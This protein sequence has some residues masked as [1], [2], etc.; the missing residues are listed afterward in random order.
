M[1]AQIQDRFELRGKP[2]ALA[3]V[4]GGDLFV[5]QHVGI[6]PQMLSTACWRGFDCLY[7]VTEVALELRELNI[8]LSDQDAERAQ[9]G[10][11]PGF[12]GLTPIVDGFS[13]FSFR[14]LTKCVPFTGG[15]LLADG[16]LR[17]LYVHMGFHPAWKYR[18]VHELLF[19]DGRLLHAYDRSAAMGELRA[20]LTRDPLQ[21]GAKASRDDI[22]RW[23]ED[24]FSLDYGG[25]LPPS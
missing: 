7:A 14:N 1:T 20:K 6:T 16:F 11:L 19:E 21:P 4:R 8:G 2:Y 18:E 13:G 9:R 3:G 5:P 17:E 24:T 23:V 22:A 15:V 25:L 12:E 10:E